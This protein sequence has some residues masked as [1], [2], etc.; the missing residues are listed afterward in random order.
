MAKA[1][2]RRYGFCHPRRSDRTGLH[3][4]VQ[5][6]ERRRRSTLARRP[7]AT[8]VPCHFVY[9]LI[10]TRRKPFRSAQAPLKAARRK[11]AEAETNRQTARL[12]S[13]ATRTNMGGN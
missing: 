13:Q 2:S 3:D 6:E 9:H 8:S 10:S 7:R 4:P 11:P 12:F 5:D 1:A